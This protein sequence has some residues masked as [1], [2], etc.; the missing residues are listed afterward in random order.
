M[1]KQSKLKATL[2]RP[3]IV[4]VHLKDEE[5]KTSYVQHFALSQGDTPA[6]VHVHGQCHA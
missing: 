4:S 1:E 3:T 2:P 6:Q 5:S